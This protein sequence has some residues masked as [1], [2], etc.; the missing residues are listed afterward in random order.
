MYSVLILWAPETIENRRVVD[1][2]TRAFEAA[3]IVPLVKNAADATIVDVN[4]AD[5]VVFGIQKVGTSDMPP[6]FS[7]F[8][9]IF[10]GITL[11]GRTGGF[12]SM[13]SEKSTARMRKV[14]RDT[15]IAQSD[16]DPLFT[17]QRDGAAPEIAEWA[18]RL[19][20]RHQEQTNVGA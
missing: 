19:V 10:K 1:A 20:G 2:V 17:D 13:G 3:R 16:E 8:V 11:A 15:E 5:I 18:R 7:E 9:R 12:F 4:R 6:D 14:L